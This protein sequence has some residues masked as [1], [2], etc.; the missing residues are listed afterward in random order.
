M[1]IQLEPTPPQGIERSK[2]R[3]DHYWI[4]S[5]SEKEHPELASLSWEV[6]GEGYV[7]EHFVL[8]EALT[9]EGFLPPDIDKARGNT[10]EYYLSSGWDVDPLNKLTREHATM[11]KISIPA[12]ETVES[13]PAYQLCKDHLY[14]DYD[15]YLCSIEDP[16]AT[17]K[18]IAALARTENASPMAIFELLRDSWQESYTKGE[19]WFFSI[20]STTF[21][22][23]VENFGPNAIKQVGD[24]V[25]FDDGRISNN[26]ELIPAMVQTDLFIDEMRRTIMESDN[27]QQR[28]QLTRSFMFFTEGLKDKDLSSDSVEFRDYIRGLLSVKNRDGAA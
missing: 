11:R 28:E 9:E 1:S 7:N 26:I 25:T 13:L 22:S 16:S 23:L 17:V 15:E 14:P 6:H 8:P 19:V 5:F 3:K 27:K 4:R 18:E 24:P 10:V 21:Q 2:S 20:V 12:G